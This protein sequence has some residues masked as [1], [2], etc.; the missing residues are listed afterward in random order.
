MSYTKGELVSAAL[1]EIGIAEYEFDI[2][3]EMRESGI[4]RLDMMIASWGSRGIKLSYP[5]A[6]VEDAESTEDTNIPDWAWEA[7]VTNLA[8]RL[9]PQYGKTLSS[10]TRTIA[11]SSY[12]DMVRRFA[13]PP[14]MQMPSGPVGAGY[15]T[16]DRRF[17]PAPTDPY[18]RPVDNNV[19]LDGVPTD[20]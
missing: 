2:S 10:D 17:S 9:A 5:I 1:E 20:E 4:A 15:K 6:K 12:L 8:V 11:R 16:V 18:L 14:Q 13:Q 7:V 19:Y 3:P